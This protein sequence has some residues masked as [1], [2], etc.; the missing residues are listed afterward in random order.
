MATQVDLGKIRPIWK[1]DWLP[2]TAYEQNDM[3]KEGANSYICI[4]AH[5]SGTEF[6]T[7]N[8]NILALGTELPLQG[9]NGGYFL[10][11]DG[12]TL[13]WES[14]VTGFRTMQTFAEAGSYT[15]T[16]S[17][18]TN[19]IK[20]YVTGGGGGGGGTPGNNADDS[21]AG[22]GAGGTAIKIIDVS[23]ITSVA[24]EIGAG[25]T[26]GIDGTSG[27]AGGTS[28]FGTYC[29]ATGGLGGYGGDS[30][31][32]AFSRGGIGT[33][34][35]LNLRGGA[36]GGWSVNVSSYGLSMNN[37]G[38]SYWSGGG[39]GATKPST[40]YTT[41]GSAASQEGLHGSGGG[42]GTLSVNAGSN[43]GAGIIIIE[44]FI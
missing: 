25:G 4:S 20:V 31:A 6:A 9:G 39:A 3:V 17:P 41:A 30:T 7:T 1:G 16:K 22:G 13:S 23:E 10:S 21:G 19:F 8:W 27:S 24:L 38:S 32:G 34:G 18:G 44:E 43:G 28:S 36:G 12:T 37:G 11:T 42:G 26:G 35:D 33:G 15:W 29:S 40:V 2:T 14:A 5:T